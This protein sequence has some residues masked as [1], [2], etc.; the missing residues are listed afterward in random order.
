MNIMYVTLLMICVQKLSFLLL[1]SL[2]FRLGH[3]LTVQN[4]ASLRVMMLSPPENLYTSFR[5]SL[6]FSDWKLRPE[7]PARQDSLRLMDPFTHRTV[8]RLRPLGMLYRPSI[9]VPL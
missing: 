5:T 8:R 2:M 6:S 7:S 4:A 1:A 9:Q 3:D